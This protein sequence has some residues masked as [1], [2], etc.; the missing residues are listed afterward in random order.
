MPEEKDFEQLTSTP[1]DQREIDRGLFPFD[2][3]EFE[4]PQK[5]STPNIRVKNPYLFQGIG[6]VDQSNDVLL[7]EGS[8]LFEFST[9]SFIVKIWIEE[10]ADETS[11][12]LWRGHITHVPSGSRRYLSRLDGMRSFIKPYLK[13]MGIKFGLYWQLR[14]QITRW[15]QAQN[16]IHVTKANLKNE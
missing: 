12:P 14:H 9:H 5:I 6:S 7:P 1:I 11:N 13:S 8:E 10:T 16:G 2:G 4:D 15:L 3:F